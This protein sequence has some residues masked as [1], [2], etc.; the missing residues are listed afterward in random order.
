MTIRG[1]GTG[2]ATGGAGSAHTFRSSAIIVRIVEAGVRLFSVASGERKL[3]NP[4]D[5]L[6]LAITGFAGSVERHNVSRR[7]RAKHFDS[8]R[9]G[10]WTGGKVPLG[11]V[12]VKVDGHSELRID[13]PSSALVRRIFGLARDG[14][15]TRAIARTLNEDP[16]TRGLRRWSGAGIRDTLTNKIYLGTMVFGLTRDVKKGGRLVRVKSTEAP[17]VVDRP[18]LRIVSDEL[19]Q[20]VASRKA[21]TCHLRRA[22]GQL[23]GKPERSTMASRYLL[24]GLR[25]SAVCAT[26][27][28]S[29]PSHGRMG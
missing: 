8:T 16:A 7:V 5:E 4:T 10:H 26:A 15:G 22:N 29:S 27:P 25:S 1:R 6:L 3:D 21:A 11:Y 12:A 17:V 2:K 13:L 24:S 20:A 19:W 14:Y 9:R 18:D 28:W 23:L